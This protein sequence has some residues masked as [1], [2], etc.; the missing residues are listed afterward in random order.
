[1]SPQFDTEQFGDSSVPAIPVTSRRR[2]AGERT[3][4][5]PICTCETEQPRPELCPVHSPGEV[6]YRLLHCEELWSALTYGV[7]QGW[8]P[9][10]DRH[11]PN[12][13]KYVHEGGGNVNNLR[14]RATVQTAGEAE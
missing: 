12:A 6:T 11:A 5:Y 1:M 10:Y 8:E 4:V 2:R 9:V 7:S 3:D 14:K 13:H